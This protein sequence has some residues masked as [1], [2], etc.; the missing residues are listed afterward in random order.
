MELKGV[1]PGWAGRGEGESV[2]LGDQRGKGHLRL[3]PG[4]RRTEAVVH[5]VP[6]GHMTADIAADVQHI[7]PVEPA[8]AAVGRAQ[9][10]QQ[11]LTR[12]ITVPAT[13]TSAVVNRS[14]GAIFTGLS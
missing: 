14:V 6:E 9:E 4:Q 1:T 11:G 13:R 12:G 10:E 7:R 8:G 5:T 2:Q 3:D